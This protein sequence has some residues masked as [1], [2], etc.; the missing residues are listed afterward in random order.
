MLYC[1]MSML[2]Q[3]ENTAMQTHN[4]AVNALIFVMNIKRKI[5]S[6]LSQSVS[7][8]CGH[9]ETMFNDPLSICTHKVRRSCCF[10][11]KCRFRLIFPFCSFRTPTWVPAG[12]C[13]RIQACLCAAMGPHKPRGALRP[14]RFTFHFHLSLCD[15]IK[16]KFVWEYAEIRHSIRRAD[17]GLSL[18]SLQ[19]SIMIQSCVSVVQK[20]GPRRTTVVS[21]LAQCSEQIR[22]VWKATN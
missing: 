9:R 15:L 12:D 11:F 16:C 10:F 14:L 22:G 5:R 2:L 13:W 3:V 1:W 8:V 4:T 21:A 20:S 7:Y 19:P 17:G 18:L 6:T